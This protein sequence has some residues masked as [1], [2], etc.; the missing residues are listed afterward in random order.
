VHAPVKN[1]SDDLKDS[2]YEELEQAFDHM[3]VLVGGFNAQVRRDNIF[4][5]TIR[6]ES[7]LQDR[8]YNGVRIVNLAI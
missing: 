3:K 4:N 6:N 7:L 2:F 8:N 5:P 1:K